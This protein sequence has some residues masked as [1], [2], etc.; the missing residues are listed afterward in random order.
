MHT[1]DSA[2]CEA[3]PCGRIRQKASNFRVRTLQPLGY[4][5]IFCFPVFRRSRKKSRFAPQRAGA[6]QGRAPCKNRLRTI[7][8]KK[9]R[10]VKPISRP[11]HQTSLIAKTT[12]KNPPA[13][14]ANSPALARGRTAGRTAAAMTG[15][16]NAP[17]LR[18]VRAACKLFPHRRP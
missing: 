14:P 13:P 10:A 17:F 2:P 3:K 16:A 9:S 12:N 18:A 4:I 11:M 1:P 6:G 15:I 7:I 5:S 8:A